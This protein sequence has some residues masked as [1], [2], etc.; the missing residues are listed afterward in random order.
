MGFGLQTRTGE[1]NRDS[2]LMPDRIMQFW[3]FVSHG[4]CKCPNTRHKL[5]AYLVGEKVW[6]RLL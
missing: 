5:R 4:P 1:E 3:F 6:V 2:L